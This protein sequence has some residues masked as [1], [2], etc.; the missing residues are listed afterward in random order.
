MILLLQILLYPFAILYGLA[1]SFRNYLYRAGYKKSAHFDTVVIS[2]GN[3][4]VGGTGKTPHVEYLIRLLKDRFKIATLSRGYGRKT[5]G[6][7]WADDRSTAETIGD[8]P[9]QFYYKFK[10]EVKVTVGE[11]RIL[12]IPTIL[13]ESET[14]VI[15]LDDAYQ[16]RKVERNL[17]ILISDYNHPFYND[18]ILPAGRLRESRRGAKRADIVV[19]SKCPPELQIGEKQEI[20]RSVDRYTKSSA[21]VFFTSIKYGAPVPVYNK[22]AFEGKI[23]AVSG[24]ARSEL[25]ETYVKGNYNFFNHLKF[26]DHHHYTQDDINSVIQEFNRIKEPQKSILITEKDMVKWQAFSINK[27]LKDYPV[28]YLPIEVEFLEGKGMFD[29]MVFDSITRQVKEIGK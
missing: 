24:I 7:I 9:M 12:A 2:V 28:F 11:K 4:T 14:E 1:T 20:K 22:M 6:F 18:F 16:H 5:K 19:I 17:D 10:N 21:P 27:I 3:L 15:L 26:K 8:E 29:Q 23:L 25:F 13:K